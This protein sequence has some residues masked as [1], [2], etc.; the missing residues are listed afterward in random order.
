ML[1]P[2]FVVMLLVLAYAWLGYPVL[3]C[4]V[5]VWRHRSNGDRLPCPISAPVERVAVLLSAHN[6][7][8][9]IIARLENLL[10]AVAH[11]RRTVPFL[12]ACRFDIYVGCDGCT[13]GT[14][15]AAR[16]VAARHTGI[17]VFEFVERRGK[18]A[19]LKELVKLSAPSCFLVFTDANTVFRED[20]LAVLL[21]PFADSRV[22]GVC[23]RLI[24]RPVCTTGNGEDESV[25]QPDMAVPPEGFYWQWE[26][27]LKELESRVDSCL[28]AN[29]AIYAI[30]R[31]LFWHDIPENTVVDDFVIGMKVR[32]Q[33]WRMAYEPLAVAEEELPGMEH[34][35]RR[36]VR[37]G[38]G[39]FQ[40]LSLC[41]R[42]LLPRYGL[43]AWAFWS[44]KVLRWF[45]PH[46]L[47]MSLLVSSSSLF[48]RA[49][50][51]FGCQILE[52]AFVALLLGGGLCVLFDRV[53]GRL[54]GK[55][56]E[57]GFISAVAHFLV[58]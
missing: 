40:A 35:W 22:G 23:G 41:R 10:M 16:E 4:L 18:V 50:P 1:F 37:I 25:A 52:G 14:A 30:R 11:T 13:D 34:E 46:L 39:D 38:A 5:A 29:G 49:P 45:T 44:H 48:L 7:E 15:A 54:G 57:A 9:H 28:G 32:E 43:F 36:R 19:V 21:R 20:A 3:L 47:L 27:R 55:K 53:L 6:E 26:N 56:C 58:M 42:C 8:R 24:L 2:P 31:E 17:H 12:A 51:Q 33:G